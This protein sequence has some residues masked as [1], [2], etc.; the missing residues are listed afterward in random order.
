MM[1]A[2]VQVMFLVTVVAVATIYAFVLDVRREAENRRLIRWLKAE[3]SADWDALTRS[4]R[5]LSIRAVEILRR[6]RLADDQEF[7]ARYRK[8]RYGARFAVAMIVAVSG[9]ALVVV[10]TVSFGWRW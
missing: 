1:D 9:I 5:F 3:R 10:G 4:D 7:H 6:G 2:S 8:T